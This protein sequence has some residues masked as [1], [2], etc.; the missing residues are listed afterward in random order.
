MWFRVFGINDAQPDPAAVLEFLHGQGGDVAGHFHGDDLGWFRA[1]LLL[2][3]TPVSLERYLTAEDDIRNDLN[4]WAA[5]LE[6]VP[7]NPHQGPLMQHMI[8]TKQLFT[9]Q[10]PGD[11]NCQDQVTNLCRY[12]ARQTDGVYQV[13]QQGFFAADGTLLVPEQP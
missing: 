5:W 7:A 8:G 11:A 4:T 13:D 2:G 1:E 3:G 6:S 12:L 9:L 10:V